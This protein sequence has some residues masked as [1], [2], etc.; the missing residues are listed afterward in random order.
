MI[1][2]YACKSKE[3]WKVSC[4]IFI[5]SIAME[6]GVGPVAG[7]S[8]HSLYYR[9]PGIKIVSPM[10]P[11]EFKSVY[12]SFMKDDSV[13]Y[14]SEHR[15]SYDNR[16]EIKNIFQKKPDLVI[17]AISI[18]RFN[19]LKATLSLLKEN[20]NISLINILWIKPFKAPQ[21][22]YENLRNSKYG[23][24]VIDDDYT[25]GVSKS[26]ANDLTLK[27]SKKVFTLG[28]K[29]RT[30]GAGKNLDNVPPTEKEIIK[31]IKKIIK[32]NV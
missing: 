19:S 3:I 30:A 28:L 6:G 10:T 24:L 8:H 4:P 22:A 18:T 16:L 9:M 7:S 15:G 17:F 5:R 29:D 21:Q 32:K 2:N 12:K 1:I 13:Y 31:Y 14:V 25:S 26:I 27:T 11:K 20:I 23:G